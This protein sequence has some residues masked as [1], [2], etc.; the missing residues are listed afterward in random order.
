MRHNAAPALALAIV[1]AFVLG[2]AASSEPV[3]GVRV[4]G[5]EAFNALDARVMDL[6]SRV[7]ALEAPEP[8]PTAEPTTPTETATLTPTPT[9]APTTAPA[10]YPDETN[11]GVPPGTTLT[12]MSGTT[13]TE[14]G[15]VIDGKDISGSLNIAAPDVTIR[16]SKIHGT[17]TYGIR[18]LSG[19]NSVHIEDSEIYGFEHGIVFANWTALRVNIHSMGVDG[20]K[21]G[22]NTRLE[23][24]YIHDFVP[25][26]GAHNDAAQLQDASAAN[27]VV[28]GNNLDIAA[29]GVKSGYGG[30][31]SIIL[32]PDLGSTLG[33]G[34]VLVEGNYLNGGNY[35]LYLVAGA[36][37][38]EL[39]DV[40]IRNN[41]WG[42]VHRYGP[43]SVKTPVA[44]EN[45]T[46]AD[47]P[48]D[49]I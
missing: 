45:N 4:P 8:E 35:T 42:R 39:Q 21:L 33:A 29:E 10:S 3:D 41:K 43:R 44:W 14:A 26:D 15:T 36:T 25:I 47:T 37:G 23:D 27:V 34:G 32:K 22:K 13:I 1:I 28:R 19:G 48:G 5:L 12:P 46:W 49:P 11:T 20:V 16:N 38:F 24:S 30:N 17:G 31:S 2:S 18:V 9:P 6:E 7:D 40:T